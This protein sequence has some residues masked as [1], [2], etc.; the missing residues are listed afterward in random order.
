MSSFSL[1]LRRSSLCFTV[2]NGEEQT[3]CHHSHCLYVVRLYVLLSLM[4][5]NK[6]R[7]IIFIG[8]HTDERRTDNENDDMTFA[9]PP[10]ETVKHTDERRTDNENGDMTFVSP[11]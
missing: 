2:S 1:S 10:L 8:T 5:R 11:H 6:R 9:S 7:V 3:A 4:G